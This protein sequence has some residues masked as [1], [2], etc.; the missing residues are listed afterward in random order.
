MKRITKHKSPGVNGGEP[1][2]HKIM[3]ANQIKRPGTRVMVPPPNITSDTDPFGD[4]SLTLPG[5]VSVQEER[6]HGARIGLISAHKFKEQ[7]D[8][9]RRLSTIRNDKGVEV[10]FKG[11]TKELFIRFCEDGY[12]VIEKMMTAVYETGHF[13]HEVREVLKPKKLFLT[14]MS[15]TGLQRSWSYRYLKV[16]EKFGDRLPEFGH[17]GIRKLIAASHLKNCV[18]Y[19]DKHTED[20]E[21]QSA[22]QFEQTVL[23]LR[24]KR[25][26]KARRRPRKPSSRPI[27]GCK[28]SRSADGSRL[29]VEGLT[30]EAQNE[31]SEVINTWLFHGKRQSSHGEK[32]PVPGRGYGRRMGTK[33][34]L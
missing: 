18:E 21:T 22:E 29:V 14:W 19:L 17:L 26:G 28:V 3:D 30:H 34:H 11:L 5:D 15:F 7:L 31:L 2:H 23:N 16:Y 12:P 24:A 6:G 32:L 20:A 8:G 1:E 13:L 33:E 10:E 9:L 25:K 4:P 27:A